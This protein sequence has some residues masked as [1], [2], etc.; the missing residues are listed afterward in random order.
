MT[1]DG[2]TRPL[3]AVVIDGQGRARLLWL[4]IVNGCS[5]AHEAAQHHQ[6]LFHGRLPNKLLQC[7]QRQRLGVR[8]RSITGVA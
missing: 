1:V 4:F 7:R 5:E 2:G 3:S 8:L 6:G